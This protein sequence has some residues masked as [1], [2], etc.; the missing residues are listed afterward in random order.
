MAKQFGDAIVIDDDPNIC[1]LLK[2]YL[3]DMGVFRNIVTA[4]DGSIA[5]NKLQNQKFAL[6]LL[7]INMPKKSGL[8]ILKEFDK[9]NPNNVNNVLIVSGEL[10]KH[11]LTVAMDRGVTNFLTKPFDQEA[12]KSKVISTLKKAFMNGGDV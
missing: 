8:D 1:S 4:A 2:T 12:F 10:A 5:A 11:T 3:E 9:N 7:D 6:I